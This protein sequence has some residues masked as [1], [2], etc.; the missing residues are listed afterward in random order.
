[1][2]KKII[3]W[4]SKLSCLGGRRGAAVLCELLET[5]PNTGNRYSNPSFGGGRGDGGYP[6]YYSRQRSRT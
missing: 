5:N 2:S 4:F 1:M 6:D 3:N